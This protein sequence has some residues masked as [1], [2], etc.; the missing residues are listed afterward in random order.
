MSD[1][2]RNDPFTSRERCIALLAKLLTKYKAYYY[3]G[4]PLL[5][6]EAYDGLEDLLREIEPEHPILASVGSPVGFEL[7]AQERRKK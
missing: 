5:S 2:A 6:D 1:T 3:A 7:A 4:Q